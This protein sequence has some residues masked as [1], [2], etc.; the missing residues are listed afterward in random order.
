M[1]KKRVFLIINLFISV[2]ML[3]QLNVNA[4]YEQKTLT[5]KFENVLEK[6][7][8]LINNNVMLGDTIEETIKI[9]LKDEIFYEQLIGSYG[10][11][12]T[13]NALEV[14]MT[15]EQINALK[16]F[17]YLGNDTKKIKDISGIENFTQLETLKL[18]KNDI[19]DIE[20]IKNLTKLKNIEI[21]GNKLKSLADLSALTNLQVLNI[22][23]NS[24][25]NLQGIKSNYTLVQLNASSNQIVDIKPITS[26]LN[27]LE[28][29]NLSTN[30]ISD[31]STIG[32]L[33]NLKSLDLSGNTSI[34]EIK[35]ITGLSNLTILSLANNN[36]ITDL[37]KLLDKNDDKE[38]TLKLINLQEL[39]L[40]HVNNSSSSITISNLT[41]LENIKVL[42]LNNNEISNISGIVKFENLETLYLNNN[43]IEKIDSFVTKK[44]SNGVT[45]IEKASPVKDLRMQN[46]EIEDIDV[47]QYL[48]NITYLDLRENHINN[49]SSIEG[50]DNLEQKKLYLQNQTANYKIKRKANT[51]VMQKIALVEM[52][53]KCKNPASKIYAENAYFEV[54]GAAKL[55]T[56]TYTNPDGT[57]GTYEVPGYYN[58]VF[59]EDVETGAV[60]TVTITGGRAA[61][62]VYTFTIT[63]ETGNKVYDSICFN[64]YYLTQRVVSELYRQER[65]VVYYVPYIINI[66]YPEISKVT[67]LVLTGSE[68]EKVVDIK[69]LESFIKLKNLNLS[70]NNISSD[71]SISNIDLLK[72]LPEMTNINLSDN[73][74]KTADV[75]TNYKN[76]T[77]IN[78]ANNEIENL[79][80]FKEW[81]E[82]II[83]KKATFKLKEIN[84]SGNKIED[85]IPIKD[86]ETLEILNISKNT[87]SDI[88]PIENMKN[89]Q[90][91]NAS[92]NNIENIEVIEGLTKL[93]MLDLSTNKIKDIGS[94]KNLSLST[95]NISNNRINSLSDLNNMA[96]LITLKVNTNKINTIEPIK[97]FVIKEFEINY[98]K[99]CYALTP[100]NEETV[101]IDLEKLF[102]EAKDENSLVYTDKDFECTNCTLTEDGKIQID[103]KNFGDKIATV[104]IKSGNAIGSQISIAQPLKPII[105]Y[106]IENITNKDVIATIEFDGR[107]AEIMNNDGKNTYTFTE[108]GKFTFDYEDEY[109]FSGTITAKVDWID[110][111]EPVIKGVLNG[112]KYNT[113]V[114]P[115]ITDD[116]LESV[117]LKKDGTIIENY[118][119][120]EITENGEYT[121]TA[122]DKAGNITVVTFTIDFNTN[123]K[124]L[125]DIEIINEPSKKI[126]KAG[127]KF[128]KTGMK[129]QAIYSD[130]SKAEVTNYEVVGENENLQAGTTSVK[131]IYTENGITKE[132]NQEITV[133]ES[134]IE[135][136]TVVINNYEE[137]TDENVKYI[138]G[139]SPKTTIQTLLN[140]METNGVIKIYK[141]TNEVTNKTQ[142][143]A[144]G[145][146]IKI[147]KGTEE[148][149]YTLVVIGDLNGDGKM[150]NIDLLKMARYKAKLD[151]NLTGA[152]LKSADVRSDGKYAD[153]IDLLKLAR[154]LVG[155][156]SL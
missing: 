3:F 35:P 81:K 93:I 52:V 37:T 40:E 41:G 46:N 25:N 139:I 89:L 110:K 28:V 149:T 111:A 39:N 71:N 107:Q 156:D 129:V 123:V 50:L 120:G 121:L 103:S 38:K 56:D 151:T 61:G 146:T 106:N 69:G 104:K 152:Y 124:T 84:V 23:D 51:S 94:L 13:D 132:K 26:N 109:G 27:N 16:E 99:L 130:G 15:I 17:E 62:S 43:K 55:N 155:L 48:K 33:S 2:I 153:D 65:E 53:Q 126:Y 67:E 96:S 112:Q 115:V 148:K 44:T 54:T 70:T 59:P 143:I 77:N 136:L 83:S 118:S 1:N 92:T 82:F 85:L 49:I 31:I 20:P 8:S 102:K 74:L 36:N 66:K 68:N 125:S 95:L 14:E 142:N 113:K 138:K 122:K 11:K 91:L 87:I 88:S 133:T 21:N 154:I 57:T 7:Y 47:I 117:E 101:N 45:T 30:N 78:L 86:I 29:L 76:I 144:T 128:D 140:N 114:T 75:I 108:N 60:A 141:G 32:Y 72:D 135:D 100:T 80:A 24:I 119:E 34:R 22:S 18:N 73:N 127:E 5:E 134:G 145:M 42:N 131:I 4:N 58:I 116:N 64:D 97:D 105:K 147:T 137:E 6:T 12:K 150:D 19:T 9:Q 63:D 90:T 98:Q 10:A 79:E